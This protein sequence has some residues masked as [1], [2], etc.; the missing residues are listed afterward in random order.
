VEEET[1]RVTELV[2]LLLLLG[3]DLQSVGSLEL[4]DP[5]LDD[6]VV[7]FGRLVVL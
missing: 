5:L 3:L 1:A 7:I 2:L 4:V 6:F